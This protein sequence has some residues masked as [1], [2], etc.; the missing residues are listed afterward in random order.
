VSKFLVSFSQ[1]LIGQFVIRRLCISCRPVFFQGLERCRTI[2][3][4][5]TADYRRNPEV[6]MLQEKIF[7]P[8]AL[9]TH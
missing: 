5:K 4:S 7:H 1:S 3:V 8:E 2:Q 9:I 6:E